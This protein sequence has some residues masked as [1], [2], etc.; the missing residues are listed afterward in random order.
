MTDSSDRF[1]DSV[2]GE[3]GSGE[4]PQ[5]PA[6]TES[7][8]APTGA[9]SAPE[10]PSR[11][12][13]APAPF[14]NYPQPGQPQAGYPEPSFAQAPTGPPPGGAGLPPVPGGPPPGTS[15]GGGRKAGL[16]VAGLL[17]VVVLVGIAFAIVNVV[18]QVDEALE[19]QPGISDATLEQL[20]AVN[21]DDVELARSEERCIED[22]MEGVATLN[23]VL[24]EVGGDAREAMVQAMLD[25]IPDPAS[26]ELLAG[27][28]G[29]N[30]ELAL[31]GQVDIDLDESGCMV[32][33]VLDNSPNPART[34]SEGDGPQDGQLMV[35]AFE[36]CLDSQDLAV[37]MGEAGTGPQAY[38]DDERFD[39]LYDDCGTGSDRACDLLYMNASADSA[40]EAYALECGGRGLGDS[41][42]CTQG[43]EFD[44]EG[45]V[46]DDDP[47]M[48]AQLA[49][50]QQGDMTACDFVFM[51]TPYGSDVGQV[52]FTCGG[53]VPIG[54]LPDCRTRVGR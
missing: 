34:L 42:W 21:D 30:V 13:P 4:T 48:V 26:S 9:P 32:Q 38:G 53:E 52:G 37:V 12:A 7:W 44:F 43:V 45:V 41:G 50:C 19:A 10:Y 25:C 47:G 36:L 35:E 2:F 24:T 39:A 8:P 22:E 18:G 29:G 15:S 5:A 31:N 23:D 46:A 40:Y 6:P 27:S 1:G 3:P 14:E 20:E 16:I 51:F 49:E 33:Y 17:G 54:A 11:P 28:F